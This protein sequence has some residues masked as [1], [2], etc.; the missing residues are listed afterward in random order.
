MLELATRRPHTQRVPATPPI[1]PGLPPT[2]GQNPG[3]P[4]RRV[5]TD[6]WLTGGCG[7]HIYSDG[8]AGDLVRRWN[9]WAVF[10][11]TRAVAE[12]IVTQHQTTVTTIMIERAGAGEHIADAWLATLQQ[13]ASTTWLRGLIVVDSRILADDPATVE[14]TT[15]DADG[16]YT[17]GWG[18]TWDEVNTADVHTVHGTTR[19]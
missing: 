13:L 12:A 10:T 8:Y 1:F 19:P 4:G 3:Q 18:W 14:I 9:G 15:P 5:F 6:D 2:G 16:N 11:V 7:C 17:I